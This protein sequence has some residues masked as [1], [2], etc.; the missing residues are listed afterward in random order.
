MGSAEVLI[1]KDLRIECKAIGMSDLRGFRD[2][3]FRVSRAISEYGCKLF[4][5]CG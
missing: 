5:L 3:R 4:G 1:I 2:L